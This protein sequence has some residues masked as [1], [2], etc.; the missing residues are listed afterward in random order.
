MISAFLH[1]NCTALQ[2]LFYL[3]HP[4]EQ[5]MNEDMT[6]ILARYTLLVYLFYN[7]LH[8]Y[9]PYCVYSGTGMYRNKGRTGLS[10]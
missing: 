6:T 8:G 10:A 9:M 2:Q 7:T 5:D 1:R 3:S 4:F